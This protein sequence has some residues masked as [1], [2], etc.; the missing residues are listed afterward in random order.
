MSIMHC[1]AFCAMAEAAGMA[2]AQTALPEPTE[3]VDMKLRVGA[4]PA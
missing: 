4:S 3:L 1:A 2:A